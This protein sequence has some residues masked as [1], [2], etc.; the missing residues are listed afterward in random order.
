MRWHEFFQ[1][2]KGAYSST[3]VVYI[4]C[5]VISSLIMWTLVGMGKMTE[6]YFLTYTGT[7]ALGFV[8]GKA[9][10]GRG[11]NARTTNRR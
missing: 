6:G 5:F 10:E 1:D 3:R 11:R 4:A 2:E 7:F 9:I 8:G